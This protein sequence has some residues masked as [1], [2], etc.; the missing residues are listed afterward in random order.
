MMSRRR[1]IQIDFT[2]KVGGGLVL[3][4]A[5]GITVNSGTRIGENVMLF[6]GCTLGGVRTGRH[7]GVPTIGN[8]VVIGLN[9]TVVGGVSIGNDVMIAPNSFVNFDV[10]PHS[11]VIGNPGVVHHKENPCRDY[12][13][14]Q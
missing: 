5:Y 1:G 14:I 12:F 8:R 10:P 6:K 9:A 7:A 11:L 4:H 3:A 13:P 2:D